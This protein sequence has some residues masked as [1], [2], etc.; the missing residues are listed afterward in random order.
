M[1]RIRIGLA[2]GSG[3][4]RGWAHLGVLKALDKLG[5]VPD[6]VAGS[7]IGSLVGGFYLAGHADAWRN[8]RAA[9][10]H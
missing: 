2:L 6:V 1:A 3:V 8:G 5:L 4:A 7:S 9:L 10:P